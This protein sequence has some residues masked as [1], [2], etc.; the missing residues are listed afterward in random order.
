MSVKCCIL[1][2]LDRHIPQ[3]TTCREGTSNWSAMRNKKRTLSMDWD[4]KL[5]NK[6]IEIKLN[7]I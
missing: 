6:C 5:R 1:K 2:K 3:A 7:L 4:S